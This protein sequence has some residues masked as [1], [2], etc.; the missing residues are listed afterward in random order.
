MH[1]RAYTKSKYTVIM[2]RTGMLTLNPLSVLS[3]RL[4]YPS[5]VHSAV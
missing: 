5:L 4:M 2:D 1:A 3:L